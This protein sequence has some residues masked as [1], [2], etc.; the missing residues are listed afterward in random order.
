MT[1]QLRFNNVAQREFNT[2]L[3]SRVDNYFR[4]KNISRHANGFMIF[5]TVFIL[6]MVF[7]CLGLLYF[8]S[9]PLWVTYMVWAILGFFT[10]LVGL[11]I[12][13]DA[14]HGSYSSNGKV[15]KFMSIFFNLIG[16][17][18]YMWN[19]THN[20]V[21]H[22]YTN[23]EGHDEDLKLVPVVRLSPHQ[24]KMAIQKY[25]HIY[26]F[27]LYGFATL[28]WVFIK[29]YKKFF[30]KK[31][32][33]HQV[34]KHPKIEYFKLF[35]FKFLHYTIYLIL[36]II[37][38][39]FAWY[40]VVLGFVLMHFVEGLTLAL[41]FALAHVVEGPDFPLP[42]NGK[43][44]DSWL[45]H[46]LKT[47]SN[48]AR[49]SKIT[50]FICGGLNFQ[51][52]HH[53]FPRICHVHYPEIAKIVKQTAE[54]YGLPYLEYPTFISALASHYNFLKKMGRMA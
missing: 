28:F 50:S 22:S 33:S 51:V 10:A 6:T 43:L 18:D 36:P 9:M 30:S 25:Q 52:E 47:T 13:H 37:L 8:A 12:G 19:I 44:E 24:P 16:A 41:I 21:H 14:I 40:W 7:G 34:K 32:G 4:E 31:V 48:F 11:N 42:E 46:Q 20:I 45:V 39:P 1:G 49:E 23:I 29:D 3:K 5:K 27:L 38:M 26:T 15:N 17:N 54:E 53:L 35:F 2:V